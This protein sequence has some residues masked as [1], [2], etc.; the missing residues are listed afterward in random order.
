MTE[1]TD[2]IAALLLAAGGSSRMGRS[3][4]L[5]VYEGETLLRRAAETLLST[6]CSCII[7]IL[8]AEL[9][10]Q[11]KRSMICRSILSITRDGERE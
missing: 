1:K 5:L 9:N 2:K 11:D 3:K 6:I 10:G 8:G 7:V 4:Q